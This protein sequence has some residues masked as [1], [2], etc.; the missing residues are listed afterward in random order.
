MS[1]SFNLTSAIIIAPLATRPTH[2]VCAS[3]SRDIDPTCRC[4]HSRPHRLCQNEFRS[5]A[6]RHL[7][8][9]HNSATVPSSALQKCTLNQELRQSMEER[10]VAP[11]IL[12]PHLK[13]RSVPVLLKQTV[14]G[15]WSM[16]VEEKGKQFCPLYPIT[17]IP[18]Q[19]LSCFICLKK[20]HLGKSWYSTYVPSYVS[21]IFTLT[22]ATTTPS[23]NTNS[24]DGINC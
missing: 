17:C 10:T 24:A 2:V 16:D 6:A 3:S 18:I 12:A 20:M 11:T 13:P 7:R 9:T 4:T 1:S 5:T 8:S 15:H 22:Q 23:E 14:I 19:V 21:G